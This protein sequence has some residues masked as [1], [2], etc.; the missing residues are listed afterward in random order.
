MA[1]PDYATV[2]GGDS[3]VRAD[4][5][6]ISLQGAWSAFGG[7]GLTGSL[8]VVSNQI[9][10][11]GGAGTFNGAYWKKYRFSTTEIIVTLP[12][13]VTSTPYYMKLRLQPSDG[14]T[15]PI[16]DPAQSGYECTVGESGSGIWEIYR[17]TAG[18]V[19]SLIQ[20]TGQPALASGDSIGFAAIGTTLTGY[21][22]TGAGA[23]AAVPGLTAVD[24][25]W[26]DG[27][28]G[29]V[30]ADPGTTDRMTNFGFGGV[31]VALPSD[32]PFVPAGRGA[33]W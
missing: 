13:L 5:N 25:R 29:F 10:Q 19:T 33:S 11:V 15:Y 14:V 31:I 28:S 4:E 6:P 18:T 23:W 12:T 26:V 3:G 9:Q 1:F 17:K 2:G 24:T 8:K 16:P 27:Y 22:K 20:V 30:L 21:R 32:Q 7:A